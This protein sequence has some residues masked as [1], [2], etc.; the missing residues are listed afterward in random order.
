[1]NR[2]ITSWARTCMARQRNKI[3]RLVVGS[4]PPSKGQRYCLTIIDRFTRWRSKAVP[5]LDIT[6]NTIV[7]AFYSTWITRFGV[8]ATVTTDRGSQFEFS[9]FQ[10]LTNLFCCKRIHTTAYHPYRTEPTQHILSKGYPTDIIFGYSN[11]R[12]M[13]QNDLSYPLDIPKMHKCPST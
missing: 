1:M 10:A 11:N 2:D 12:R 8:P 6:T 5:I 4:L 3:H 7:T 9:F 13:F